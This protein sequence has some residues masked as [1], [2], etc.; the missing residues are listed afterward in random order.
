[1]LTSG[2]TIA[3]PWEFFEDTNTAENIED[4]ERMLNDYLEFASSQKND[5]S[6]NYV[7]S[8]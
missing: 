6:E 7:T 1:M 4:M 5:K 2:V 3:I 8:L